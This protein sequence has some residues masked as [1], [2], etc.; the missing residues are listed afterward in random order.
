MSGEIVPKSASE[1][2]QDEQRSADVRARV[3]VPILKDYAWERERQLT[4]QRLLFE[5]LNYK[6]YVRQGSLTD[7]LTRLGIFGRQ[8]WWLIGAVLYLVYRSGFYW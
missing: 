7:F 2:Q 8:Y 4:S 1:V 3:S 5:R 6:R